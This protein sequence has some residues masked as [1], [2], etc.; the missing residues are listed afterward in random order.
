VPLLIIKI[1]RYLVASFLFGLAPAI[2]AKSEAQGEKITTIAVLES[3]VTGVDASYRRV[4]SEALTN[5]LQSIKNVHLVE[6]TKL[7]SI[8]KEHELAQSGLTCQVDAC[9]V[10]VGEMAAAQKVLMSS[11]TRTMSGYYLDVRIIDVTQAKVDFTAHK[12]FLATEEFSD[13][14]RKIGLLLKDKYSPA[15]FWANSYIYATGGAA[16]PAFGSA[17]YLKTGWTINFGYY[18]PFIIGYWG[19]DT[20]FMSLKGITNYS[21]TSTTLNALSGMLSVIIPMPVKFMDISIVTGA[22]ASYMWYTV[23]PVA[24][25]ENSVFPMFSGG[26][27]LGTTFKDINFLLQGRYNHALSTV[28]SGR[29]FRISLGIRYFL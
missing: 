1:Q 5:E 27:Q 24:F 16:F 10:K 8:L 23:S 15:Y 14:V 25:S 19:I 4:L 22:G 20:D 26:L 2:L 13:N 12:E 29:F 28:E 7:N 21:N 11:F 17:S 18:T 3:E 9:A 6:R